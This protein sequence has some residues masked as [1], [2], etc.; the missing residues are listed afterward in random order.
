MIWLHGKNKLDEFLNHMNT[1]HKTIKFRW[2][3]SYK[4]ISYLDVMIVLQ[5]GSFTTDLY[6]LSQRVHISFFLYYNSCHP[7][8]VNWAIPYRQVLK[9]RVKGNERISC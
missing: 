4:K 9:L 5:D 7:P 3:I 8:N 2:E 6:T 1:R